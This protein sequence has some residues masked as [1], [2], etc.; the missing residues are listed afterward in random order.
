MRAV[1]RGVGD[2]KAVYTKP[3]FVKSTLA[4]MKPETV[5]FIAQLIRQQ[6]ALMSAAERFIES[7]DFSQ[8]EALNAI[9]I[10]RGVLDNYEIQLSKV[11]TH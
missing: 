4:C 9:L 1:R 2:V 10:L 7:P 11:E 5:H 6:R 3:E 8:D